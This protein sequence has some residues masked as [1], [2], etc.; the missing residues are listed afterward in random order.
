MELALDIKTFSKAKEV[1]IG[2]CLDRRVGRYLSCL[3]E[4]QLFNNQALRANRYLSVVGPDKGIVYWRHRGLTCP[5]EGG[6]GDT[7]GFDG[8]HLSPRGQYKLYKSI[9]RALVHMRHLHPQ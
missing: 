2:Q 8:V 4:E 5:E 6:M 9:K 3:Q 7:L 1:F